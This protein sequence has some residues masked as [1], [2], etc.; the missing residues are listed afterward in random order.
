[1]PRRCLVARIATI[2]KLINYSKL[3]T[4]NMHAHADQKQKAS[5]TRAEILNLISGDAVSIGNISYTLTGVLTA[6]LEL[7]LGGFYI[8][9]LLGMS[10]F[11]STPRVMIRRPGAETRTPCRW[12]LTSTRPV[13]PMGI[14]GAHLH[15][16]PIILYQQASVQAVPRP[17]RQV[18]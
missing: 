13:R 5:T 2:G 9:Q 12:T 16:D 17:S 3:L 7:L 10:P 1:M 4:R 6:H 8:W 14:Y 18:G 11:A 15:L